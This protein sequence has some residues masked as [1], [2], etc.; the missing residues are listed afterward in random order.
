MTHLSGQPLQEK[1]NKRDLV[2]I[3]R[4]RQRLVA[5]AKGYPLAVA[6]LWSPHCH[7][8]DGLGKRSKRARGC[9]KPM[10]RISAGVWRC[11]TCDI[12]EER[13][14]QVEPI[15]K[16]G[17]EAT[18]ISGGNRAGKTEV[19]AMIAVAFAAGSSAPFV[20]E[21]MDL[22]NIPNNLI[23]SEPS[24]VW[25]SALSYADA[26]SYVR[27]KLSKFV[28]ETTKENNWRGAGRS[29]LVL[30]NGGKIISMSA[31]SGREKYQGAGGDI[32]LIWLDEEHPQAVFEEC[33]M[34]VVDSKGKLM[35]TMTPL[36]GLTWVYDLFIDKPIDGY[37]RH[38]ISG[39]D[40]PW[41]SSV[42]L[43][44]AVRHMSDESRA[45]RLYGDFTN[46]QGLVYPELSPDIHVV[47]SHALPR[48]W[49]RDMSIDFGVKNPF[50]CLVTA[51]DPSDDTLHVIDEFYRTEHTTLQNG[52]EIRKRF[53]KYF[54]VRWTVADPESKDGRLILARNCDIQTR[55]APKWMGV[56]ETINLVK[57]R[58]ALDAEGKPHLVIHDNCKQLLKEFRLYR[59][60]EKTGKDAPVKRDDHGLDALRY[61]VSF[62][63]RWLRHQ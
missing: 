54:P 5:L 43:S 42:K 8:F 19:G 7:R 40:N 25:A 10:D 12:T 49:P 51:W 26:I 1:L 3:L 63:Y 14:S 50:A 35:L 21:W 24:T 28:P 16:L 6:K 48:E 31:D 39:L 22:N 41:I 20:K 23:P 2:D 46:Q 56:A 55:I 15:H 61:Q 52:L 53:K 18:L 45:S 60:A 29:Q 37:V 11:E 59:W 30:P 38:N 9:G 13:T 58:L 57:E 4:K 27:P 33:L 17:R 32:S 44:R 62:L 34:R 36:K 47:K